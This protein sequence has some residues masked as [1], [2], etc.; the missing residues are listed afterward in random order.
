MRVLQLIDS[1]QPGGAER[2]AVNIANA[3]VVQ[4]NASFLCST[5]TEGFLKKE[6]SPKVGYLSTG[7]KNS[8]DLLAFKRLR[9]FV[10]KQDIGVV[11]AHGTSWFW[12]VLL[13]FSGLKI[14]LVWHDH[15]GESATQKTFNSKFLKLGS[16]FFDGVV[17]VNFESYAWVTKYLKPQKVIQLNNFINPGKLKEGSLKLKGKETNFKII[18]VSNL[19][20]Q[21]DLH[22][23]L[24]AFEF[25][26]KKNISLHIVGSNNKSEYALS[27]I[28]RLECMSNVYYY[29]EQSNI[30]ALLAQA[31]M[32][33]LSSRTEGLPL[34][35][36]EYGNSRIP[37]VCTNVGHCKEVIGKT[38][39]LVE[40]GD[41][42]KL[43]TG[44]LD[45]YLHPILMEQDSKAF[46]ERVSTVFSP[47]SVIEKLMQFYQTL[48]EEDVLNKDKA[49]S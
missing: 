29:G 42:K 17:C 16:P 3:L 38:G 48:V 10:K 1:L 35:L 14:K 24:N 22:N 20:E 27:V 44:I 30:Q 43:A 25:I 33:I 21:K 32:G 12:G 11:H 37:V 46:F 40:P 39:K 19:R 41:P 31:D 28:K 26:N 13:K 2:M 4:V 15:Y 5:R 9:S 7:K 49:N 23:L 18:C 34:V 47:V 45:Y 36:L 8:L 6:L